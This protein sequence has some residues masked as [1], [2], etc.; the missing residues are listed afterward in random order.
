M[1]ATSSVVQFAQPIWRGLIREQILFQFCHRGR[2]YADVALELPRRPVDPPWCSRYQ[3]HHERPKAL[4]GWMDY[5]FVMQPDR[6]LLINSREEGLSTL[7]SAWRMPQELL[8]PCPLWGISD[9]IAQSE[10][11]PLSTD[12]D[13]KNEHRERSV[14]CHIRAFGRTLILVK[15]LLPF[16]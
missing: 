5:F 1:F 9:R 8:V 16:S 10:R 12:S 2:I 3:P 13:R 6:P 15:L 4:K 11:C 7:K 14:K